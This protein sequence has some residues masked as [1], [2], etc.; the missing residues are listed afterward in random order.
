MFYFYFVYT[1][2]LKNVD[3]DDNIFGARL[4]YYINVGRRRA[5]QLYS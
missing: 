3:Q 4:V 2:P 1:T 5:S